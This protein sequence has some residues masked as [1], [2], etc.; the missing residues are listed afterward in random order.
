MKTTFVLA[1]ILATLGYC[2]VFQN[3]LSIP[4]TAS[5]KDTLSPPSLIVVN[6]PSPAGS[7]E[8]H[9]DNHAVA[10]PDSKTNTI[11]DHKGS[12]K[13][14]STGFYIGMAF[15]CVGLFALWMCCFHSLQA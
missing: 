14:P 4:S 8:D 6:P 1:V 7:G 5:P 12:G 9:S 10:S 2:V 13:K 3:S 15:M 11:T